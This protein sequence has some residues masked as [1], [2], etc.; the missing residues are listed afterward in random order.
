MVWLFQ[1]EVIVIAL[2]V[3][4]GLGYGAMAEKHNNVRLK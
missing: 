2:E 3:F 4:S 1:L